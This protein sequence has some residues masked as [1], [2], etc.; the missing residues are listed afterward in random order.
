MFNLKKIKGGKVVYIFDAQQADLAIELAPAVMAKVLG[1][2]NINPVADTN[3]IEEKNG[4]K[5][6]KE[7][8]EGSKKNEVEAAVTKPTAKKMTKQQLADEVG[9]LSSLIEAMGVSR[10]G[11]WY[12]VYSEFKEETGVNVKYIKKST[13]FSRSRSAASYNTLI[14]QGYG[15]VLVDILNKVKTYY[16]KA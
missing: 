3:L 5:K 13:K 4:L 8:V 15:F 16:G 2:G 6:L 10:K 11:L 9:R 1:V 14:D 12:E 7:K